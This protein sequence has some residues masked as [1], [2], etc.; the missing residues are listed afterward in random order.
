MIVELETSTRKRRS[1]RISE[2]I[3]E[4][5]VRIESCLNVEPSTRS[6]LDTLESEAQLEK[7]ATPSKLSG[8]TSLENYTLRKKIPVEVDRRLLDSALVTI[9][10]DRWMDPPPI[11]PIPPIDPLVRPRGLPIVVPQN[12]Q[13]VDIPSHLPKFYGT[14]DEDPSRHIERYMETLASSLVTNLGY[15]LVWF[16]TTLEG[17]A[18]EW[19]RDNAEGHFRGW[20]QL[21]RK[22][23]N[24]FRPEVG[25]STALRTLASLKQGREKKIS[26]YIRRFDLVCTRFVGTMLNDDTLKQFFIQGFFKSGTIRGV[27]ERNPQTLADTKRAAREMESLDRDHER[28]SRREDEFIPQFIPIRL[29]VMVGELVKYES[30][31]PYAIV[32]TGPRSS[33]VREP[34]PLLALPAPIVDPYLDEVERRLVASQLGFQEAMI[35]QMQN[36]TDQMSL[37]IKSQQPGP[38]PLVESGRHSSR[39]WCVQCGQPG[40]TRQFCRS[41]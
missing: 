38:P 6:F 4:D 41:G 19:Y 12:L 39:L 16:P 33:A 24:E 21:Q 9:D 26:A 18:Y 32:D 25:Q 27:L 15:W 7:E 17:E 31:V 11:P 34:A 40:H 28:L 23:L 3:G 29:T 5:D 10:P 8:E 36:L 13:A 20:D 35:K 37:V 2:K 30:Q 14:K 22:F 1:S